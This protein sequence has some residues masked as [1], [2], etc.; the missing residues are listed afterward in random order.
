MA[1]RDFLK[2]HGVPTTFVAHC[3][4]HDPAGLPLPFRQYYLIPTENILFFFYF[5]N[6][7]P[8]K[9]HFTRFLQYFTLRIAKDFFAI[10]TK[11]SSLK[12][13]LT[14]ANENSDTSKFSFESVT[15]I[16][17]NHNTLESNPAIPTSL[18]HRFN[19]VS[20]RGS[21]EKVVGNTCYL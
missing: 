8:S 10:K 19:S 1:K 20:G 21:E 16:K 13:V 6:H 5:N 11:I 18:F 2:S 3:R 7:I 14:Q 4:L 17:K 15:N 12:C 9:T